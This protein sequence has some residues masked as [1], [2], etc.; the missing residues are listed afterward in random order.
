MVWN[1]KKKLTSPSSLSTERRAQVGGCLTEGMSIRT[2]VGVTGAAKNTIT[3]L[4]VDLGQAC[5]EW[6]DVELANL[7]CKRIQCDEIWSYSYAK[8]LTHAVSLHYLHY[9]FARPHQSLTIKQEGKP[10]TKR[11][12]AMAAGVSDRI[13]SATDIATLLD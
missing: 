3:S 11:T 4:L 8:N 9:N 12:P 10:G 6:Q 5:A 1:L 2:T 7:D 13:W